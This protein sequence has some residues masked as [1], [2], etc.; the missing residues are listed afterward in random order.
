MYALCVGICDAFICTVWLIVMPLFSDI[1]CVSITD[2]SLGPI[3]SA[4]HL[5]I[6]HRTVQR[7]HYRPRNKSRLKLPIRVGV[8]PTTFQIA[9]SDV[10]TDWCLSWQPR[11]FTYLL[12]NHQCFNYLSIFNRKMQ[13]TLNAIVFIVPFSQLLSWHP[14]YMRLNVFMVPYL[15]EVN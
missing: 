3:I 14:A 12:W 9:A 13:R 6:S 2:H 1:T 15:Y 5:L 4:A 8:E 10:D 7:W 11:L